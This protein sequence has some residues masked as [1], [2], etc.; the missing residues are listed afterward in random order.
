MSLSK[1]AK[2][3]A[4]APAKSGGGKFGAAPS[5]PSRAA[6]PS[7]FGARQAPEP[8]PEPEDEEPEEQAPPQR[9]GRTANAP[10]TRGRAQQRGGTA[11][12]R[13]YVPTRGRY[14]GTRSKAEKPPW[15]EDGKH[16][17][18]IMKTWE[19]YKKG[20]GPRFFIQVKVL[21]S[22]NPTH[23]EGELRTV[24]YN[25]DDRAF[26]ATG[27][28]IFMFCRAAAGFGTDAEA[29]DAMGDESMQD[30]IDAAHGNPEA[31]QTLAPN[32]K[33]YGENPL[34]G[35]FVIAQGSKGNMS[36][37]GVQFFD[38]DWFPAEAF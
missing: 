1:F 35:S 8:E 20:T 23:E 19:S 37:N 27:E 36:D 14:T 13:Q 12:E 24:K 15:L 29:L 26:G 34:V 5:T 16:H 10:A 17:L 30:L 32:G 7:K 6:A 31:Q 2:P 18:E 33:P 9:F 3:S 4:A 11:G 28:S 38:F 21:S 22:N 25:T